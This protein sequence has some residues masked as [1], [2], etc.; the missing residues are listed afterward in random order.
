MCKN[1]RFC[2]KLIALHA[3]KMRKSSQK[4]IFAQKIW[5]FRGNPRQWECSLK[6]LLF[7]L[8]YRFI[9]V[10]LFKKIFFNY[11]EN[12]TRLVCIYRHTPCNH[13]SC[14]LV[15][16]YELE[17]S[18]WTTSTRLNHVS[19]CALNLAP[20]FLYS[21]IFSFQLDPRKWFTPISFK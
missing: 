15:Q 21:E 20:G 4:K 19:L 12:C 17:W 18:S 7:T 6:V 3:Q 1:V 16:T 11:H 14:A 8:N 9:Q 10:N 5:S 2:A 13:F